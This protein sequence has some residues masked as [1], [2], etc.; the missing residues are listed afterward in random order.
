MKNK[1]I[2]PI[3][4]ALF[5]ITSLS[6]FTVSCTPTSNTDTNTNTKTETSTELMAVGYKCIGSDATY[7]VFVNSDKT[8][9]ASFPN[10]DGL[11]LNQVIVDQEVAGTDVISSPK[12]VSIVD[13]KIVLEAVTSVIFKK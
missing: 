7:F 8:R 3:L 6:F 5:I 2:K 10:T 9:N 1:N 4:F 11:T 12:G 13:N